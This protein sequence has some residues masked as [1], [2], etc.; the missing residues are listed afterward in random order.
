MER[1]QAGDAAADQQR[2]QKCRERR[3][4]VHRGSRCRGVDEALPEV[5]QP[6]SASGRQLS[7][8]GVGTVIQGDHGNRE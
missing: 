8:Q 2:P 7:A 5:V 6:S 1:G 3:V 4:E